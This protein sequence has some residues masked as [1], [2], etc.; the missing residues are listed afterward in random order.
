MEKQELE[1]QVLSLRQEKVDWQTEVQ[2]FQKEAAA[3]NERQTE[4]A[5]QIEQV[6]QE[7]EKLKQEV[8]RLGTWEKEL[9]AWDEKVR[10][11][12][13]QKGHS[14]TKLENNPT[15]IDMMNRHTDTWYRR[16][17]LS[18]ESLECVNGG[19]DGAVVAAFGVMVDIASFDQIDQ[20]MTCYKKGKYWQLKFN[21]VTKK[22]EASGEN[23]E[24]SIAA[25]FRGE[26]SRRKYQFHCKTLSSVYD[27]EQAVYLP[28]NTK[29]DG[30]NFRQ[31]R[32]VSNSKLQ[33]AISKM[34][35]GHIHPVPGHVGATR[36]L[37]SLVHMMVDLHLR[38]PGLR[39]ELRWF[40]G[41]K[42]HFIIY[43]A[44]DGTPET[45]DSSMCVATLSCWN[46]GS[47]TRSREYQYL[48]HIIN[49]SEKSPVVAELWG[50]HL[51]QI[52][53][54]ISKAYTIAGELCT[55][56]FRAGGDE[57][58]AATALGETSGAATYPSPWANVTKTDMFIVGGN[59]GV[60]WK[61]WTMEQ[62]D[63]DLLKLGEYKKS[64]PPGL[65]ES[66]R[67]NK[68]NEFM[69]AN[70][71][72]QLRPPLIGEYASTFYPDCLHVELNISNHWY[73]LMYQE[74]VRRDRVKEF[75][76]VTAAPISLSNARNEP[77]Q[78][79]N[80]GKYPSTVSHEAVGDRVRHDGSINVQSDNMYSK[81][82]AHAKKTQGEYSSL[83]GLGMKAIAARV[84]EHDANKTTRHRK[85]G[86]RFI[87][88][89]AIRTLRYGHRLVDS[90]ATPDEDEKGKVVREV[91][92]TMIHLLRD[93]ASIY[94]KHETTEA[95]LT[96][97][98][99]LLDLYYNLFCLFLPERANLTVWTVAKAIPHYARKLYDEYGVGYGVVSMQGKEAKNAKVKEYLKLTNHSKE[100]DRT[101]K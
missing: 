47:K 69:A 80:L 72:R 52:R 50:E 74:A 45:K 56:E 89:N 30:V 78:G 70:G 92:G 101:R 37:V 57:S 100:E 62:R 65:S 7:E 2:K 54:M 76:D 5:H 85:L 87:G 28:R 99:R 82:E 97:M 13:D 12:L 42:N 20:L 19:S 55:F 14:R 22:Y 25:K 90:L 34:D 40:N 32:L 35:I 27:P 11:V 26:F 43:F 36:P 79:K 86:I 9:K 98:E 94:N 44:D 41:K 23:M 33:A 21:S 83:V 10:Q 48:L 3:W 16:R 51:F 49:E 29:I 58:W 61:P 95:E 88:E 71:M 1:A 31:A 39:K 46:F 93:A 91:L 8:E 64:L 4:L 24:M 73:D 15:T 59:I 63:A 68:R 66:A 75:T 84:L 17:R 38:L 53:M 96:E 18:R 60:T 67:R 77:A 6:R 81:L